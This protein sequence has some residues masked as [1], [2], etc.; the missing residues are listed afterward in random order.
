MASVSIIIPT[1]NEAERIGPLIGYL[2]KHAPTATIWIADSP[3]TI[4]QT[5]QIATDLGVRVLPCP[6]AGRAAQMNY[7]AKHATGDLLYFV[8]AD[9]FPAPHFYTAITEAVA[10]GHQLGYFCMAFDSPSRL[11]QFNSFCTRR[12]TL[13]S[14]GGDQTLFIQ[15]STF[16]QLEGFREDIPLMEDFDLVRRAKKAN[17]NPQLLSG[18]TLVSARKYEQNSWLKV[19][20]I[21]LVT[22]LLFYCNAPQQW[23]VHLQ[24]QLQN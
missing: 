7:A 9:V 12:D 20:A 8:H 3:N 16:E 11:L 22:I 14:G 18:P 13:F 17:L 21:N 6:V 24:R 23:L 19:N 5:T 1:Y 4:D 10:E 2:R 15:R